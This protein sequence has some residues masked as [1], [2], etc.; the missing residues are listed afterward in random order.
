MYVLALIAV[1]ASVFLMTGMMAGGMG[2]FIIFVDFP[3]LILVLII[4]I[5]GLASSGLLRDFNNAFSVALGK[6][7]NKTLLEMKRAREAVEL[8]RKT[9]V[10]TG[11][12]TFLF[13][14]V[15]ILRTLDNPEALGPNVAV[16]LLTFIYAEILNI[17]LLPISSKIKV[18][19]LE[20]LHGEL[21]EKDA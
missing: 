13:A 15:V 11:V 3:S 6:K 8:A 21:P 10:A 17:L 4:L 5:P 20:Y 1:F 14:L 2:N 19:E 9:L 12:F 7:K 16:A 18:K